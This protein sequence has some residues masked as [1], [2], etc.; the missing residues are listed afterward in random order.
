MEIN[1]IGLGFVGL[2]TAIGFSKKGHSIIGI[3]K[4][5]SILND[6][7]RKKIRIYEPGLKKNL[8]IA[9]KKKKIV[10][11]ENISLKKK[12]I[13]FLCVGTPLKQDGFYETKYLI[14]Y[15]K[16]ILKLNKKKKAEIIFFLVLSSGALFKRSFKTTL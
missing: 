8:E 1:V 11:K 9:L 7:K 4:N 3:E 13:F 10:F 5:L 16:Y 6:L 2:T 14:N 15:I 12:N